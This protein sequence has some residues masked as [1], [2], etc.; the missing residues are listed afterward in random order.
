[1]R[2]KWVCGKDWGGT[3]VAA[4][5]AGG[6]EL[7]GLGI[8]GGTFDPPHVGHLII[9]EAAREA[10]DLG[11]VLFVPASAQPHKLDRSVTP[12]PQRWEMVKRA[13]SGN[14]AFEASD[15]EFRRSGPSYTAETVSELRVRSPRRP[16]F[17]VC[18]ADALE[19]LATW[20]RPDL[21]LAEAVVA[22]AERP[23]AAGGRRLRNTAQDLARS[24]GGTI[25]G[26]HAP[27]IDVSSTLVRDMAGRGESV[28]YLV[29]EGVFTYIRENG[30]YTAGIER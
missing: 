17:F 8:I 26:F 23:G 18:G 20:H 3:T 30:L 5:G 21:I 9:A 14:P 27:L 11:T 1:M 24:Y 6:E 22:V 13:I 2:V 29:P 25:V 19:E 12:P 28:R 10:L 15:L 7:P 16:L 4:A